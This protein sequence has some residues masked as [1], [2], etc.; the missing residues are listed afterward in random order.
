MIQHEKIILDT[1]SYKILPNNTSDKL[2]IFFSGTDKK[3]GRFDFYRVGQEVNANVMLVNNGIN[4]WYQNGIPDLG[5]SIDNTIGSLKQIIQMLKI[6]DVYTCGVS[7][8][9]YGAVLFATKLQCNCLAFGFDSMLKVEESRSLKRMPKNIH[10][11]YPDLFPLIQN[12]KAFIN[13]YAGEIDTMDLYGASRIMHLSNVNVQFLRGVGHGAAPFLEK[14]FGLTNI[15]D[16]FLNGKNLP[17]SKFSNEE[18]KTN[19]TAIEYLWY[20]Y[21]NLKD[22]AKMANEYANEAK[23][24]FPYSE[25]I[26]YMLGLIAEKEKRFQDASALFSIVTSKVPHFIGAQHKLAISL[27]KIGDMSSSLYAYEKLL[28]MK[29]D[30]G[31]AMFWLAKLYLLQN[32]LNKS[33]EYI[34]KA[35]DINPDKEMFN[36]FLQIV[37]DSLEIEKKVFQNYT[38]ATSYNIYNLPS[39]SQEGIIWFLPWMKNKNLSPQP[40]HIYIN[41]I[42]NS[43][44]FKG[45]KM[46]LKLGIYKINRLEY[47]ENRGWYRLNFEISKNVYKDIIAKDSISFKL[48]MK[49][50]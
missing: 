34:K 9:G 11:K 31:L 50:T 14:E 44:K 18:F 29:P 37:K 36:D 35:L 8:G 40:T 27:R 3:N 24:L 21:R 30:S 43:K 42:N 16:N 49:N 23:L 38:E 20:A 17:R 47:N 13:I 19:K 22:N 33:Y 1:N 4:A 15:I 28:K 48:L 45:K 6:K 7:M 10:I 39:G 32:K 5:N 25:T 41:F 46:N 12:S 2:I 26:D